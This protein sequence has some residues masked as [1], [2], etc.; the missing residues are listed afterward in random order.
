[1][2]YLDR[3]WWKRLEN[4]RQ[5]AF[6]TAGGLFLIT[7]VLFGLEAFTPVSRPVWVTGLVGSLGLIV[8]FVG[9]V[10]LYPGLR[11]RE[12]R[13]ARAGIALVAAAVLGLIVFLSCLLAK[14]SGIPLPAPPIIAFVG[15]MIAIILVF[16]LFGA[17]SLRSGVH[18]RAV[19]LLIFL[20]VA[21]F[22]GGLI[23]DLAY[24]GSPATVN[25]IMN[26]V[27]S[28]ILLSIGYILPTDP[29]RDRDPEINIMSG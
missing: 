29:V 12:P 27:L 8:A 25:A 22:V 18:S 15:A 14:M 13:L 10:G 7:T 26:G 11:D 28:G 16:V 3:G 6:V 4:G 23:A 17:A 24:G 19:G 5:T 20:L 2:K 21:T 1:M 9:L